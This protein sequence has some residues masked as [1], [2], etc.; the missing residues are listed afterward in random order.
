MSIN[1]TSPVTLTTTQVV[2][3]AQ[4][5]AFLDP[6]NGLVS[7]NWRFLD[8]YG[9]PVQ[10]NTSGAPA[11]TKAEQSAVLAMVSQPGETLAQLLQR[12]AAP[13]LTDLGMAG[14]TTIGT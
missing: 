14:A 7:L 11:M 9:R 1:L 3:S 6:T 12:A 5:T 2:A 10:V 8:G 4:V 13:R